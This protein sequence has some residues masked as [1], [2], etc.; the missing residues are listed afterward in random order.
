MTNLLLLCLCILSFV[1]G[2]KE[3]PYLVSTDFEG[4]VVSGSIEALIEE[5]QAGKA[6]RVGWKLDFDGDQVADLE[7]WVNA[8]FLTVMEGHVFHQITPIYRQIP[9]SEIP[10]IEIVNSPMQWTGIIGTNG[11]LVHRYLL[12]D[13]DS[14]E[15]E[16]VRNQMRARCEIKERI[17]ATMWVL[18]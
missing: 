9:K 6:I 8:D 7:H 14:I 4:K 13:I 1:G 16:F 17:V 12:E 2:P 18:Q 11:K 3:S 10:Q 15:D 5:V